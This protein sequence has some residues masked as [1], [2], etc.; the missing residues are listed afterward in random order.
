MR[1]I[2]FNLDIPCGSF[3][4]GKYYL[5]TIAGEKVA[6]IFLIPLLKKSAQ[7]ENRPHRPF[8]NSAKEKRRIENKLQR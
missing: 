3:I 1:Y 5:D 2:L 8:D 4:F 7:V 6:K